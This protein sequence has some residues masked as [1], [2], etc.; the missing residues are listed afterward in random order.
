[1]TGHSPMPGLPGLE[2]FSRY[3]S[4]TPLPESTMI[5]TPEQTAREGIESSERFARLARGYHA[6]AL[7]LY[8]EFP[9]QGAE[10]FI[11][12]INYACLALELGMKAILSAKGFSDEELRRTGH[13]LDK[14]AQSTKKAASDLVCGDF[15]PRDSR[16][17]TSL[18]VE[19]RAHWF[20]YGR[21]ED[22]AENAEQINCSD[23]LD[24][25]G[26]VTQFCARQFIPDGQ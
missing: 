20:R 14:L 25:S 26:R 22:L 24:L 5:P 1:M 8:R 15:R 12:A 23:V 6:A 4:E 21:T 3:S 13:D 11:P 17:V 10:L 16:L 9:S 19:Y 2:S 18:G 7:V